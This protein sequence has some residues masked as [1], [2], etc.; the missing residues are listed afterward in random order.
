LNK[1]R[2]FVTSSHLSTG[3]MSY[4]AQT[5]ASA[6]NLDI[7]IIDNAF[8]KEALID[9][10]F[11]VSKLHEWKA[12]FDLSIQINNATNLKPSLFKIVKR[13]IK[14]LP[15]IRAIYNFLLLRQ[16]HIV[17]ANQE[18]LV[19]NK[20]SDVGIEIQKLDQFELFLLTQTAINESL[21][22]LLPKADV[23]Y[24]EHGL[25]DYI[26]F[27]KQKRN[28]GGLF[29]FAN[30]YKSFLNKINKAQL[31]IRNYIDA[32]GF[33]Q[34]FSHYPDHV[35]FVLDS[36]SKNEKPIV[37][38]LMDAAEIYLPQ[39]Q[40]WTDYIDKCLSV[41]DNTGNYRIIVKPH[42][43]QSNEVLTI[44]RNYFEALNLDFVML[45]TPAFVSLSVET[46]YVKY[47][48]DVKYVFS[49]FSSA[50]F[51]L[52]EY[53]SDKSQF[54]HLYY[55]VGKYFS[56]APEQYKHAYKELGVLIDQVFSN[57][58]CIGLK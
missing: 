11:H 12:T 4:Y 44:T 18:R 13:K 49:T 51:Y 30:K 5:T 16:Q 29:I 37:L 54:Y 42:P 8:K 22:N 52:A 31:Q 35:K 17:I 46:I 27:Q 28:N 14:H 2:L 20:L 40:F 56:N 57:D 25:G 3:L 38:F 6:S 36:I 19:A 23:Y 34:I 15:I 48:A 21:L 9:L 24:M 50:L 7:L 41:I 47:M 1:L 58:K 53:Y 39:K 43:L 32:N 26:Y 45:D 10:I 33:A 55:F